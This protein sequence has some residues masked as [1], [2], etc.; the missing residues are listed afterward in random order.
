MS[1]NQFCHL[2]HANLTFAV[3]NFP[4]GFVGIYHGSLFLILTTVLPNVGPQLF[5]YLRAR[6]RFGTDNC[7]KL[8]IGLHWPHKSGT[9]LT[10]RSCFWHGTLISIFVSPQQPNSALGEIDALILRC[11]A[12]ASLGSV[13]AIPSR[14][15]FAGS[16]AG[17]ARRL[18]L[19]I[20]AFFTCLGARIRCAL[21]KVILFPGSGTAA[22]GV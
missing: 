2:E 10:F 13:G 20:V 9:R 3:E 6:K 8:G 1:G 7:G 5:G 4:Q 22:Q 19:R 17:E 14:Y 21:H 18:L 11:I 15:L 12:S 16:G